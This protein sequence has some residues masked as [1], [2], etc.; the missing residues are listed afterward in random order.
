[1][2]ISD[3]ILTVKELGLNPEVYRK[4]GITDYPTSK[5]AIMVGLERNGFEIKYIASPDGDMIDQAQKSIYGEITALRKAFNSLIINENKCRDN[6]FT[7]EAIEHFI[8]YIE[9]M[10][11]LTSL[12]NTRDKHGRVGY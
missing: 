3:E 5:E 6:S 2:N 1:M 9:R 12:Y 7:N 10:P 4:H 11:Y 8:E